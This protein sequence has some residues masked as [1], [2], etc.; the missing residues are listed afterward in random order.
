MLVIIPLL[1]QNDPDVSLT[2]GV[3]LIH[4]LATLN[5]TDPL[6]YE[7]SSLFNFIQKKFF[8]TLLLF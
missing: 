3:Q 5:A 7:V 2:L 4:K 1:N 6:T 8:F